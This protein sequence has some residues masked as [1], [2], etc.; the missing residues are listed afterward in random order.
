MKKYITAI[1]AVTTT[2]GCVY[3]SSCKPKKEVSKTACASSPT[4]TAD[5]KPIFDASC[6][7]CHSAEKHKHN[8]D[9]SSYGSSKDAAK[10]KNFLGSLRHKAGYEPMPMKKDKLAED[11]IEKI[12]C[13]IQNGMPQ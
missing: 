11:V 13:W 4:F 1:I 2:A 6:M 10:G 7:P 5:I 12:S 8:I 3:L 9:L